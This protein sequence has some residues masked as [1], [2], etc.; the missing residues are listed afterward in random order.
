VA[1]KFPQLDLQVFSRSPHQFHGNSFNVLMA[2]K[3]AYESDARY[4]FMVEDDVMIHP[5]FFAWHRQQHVQPL[6]CSIAGPNPTK[7]PYTSLGVCFERDRLKMVLPHCRAEYFGNMRGYCK[8]H[9]PPTKYDCE[10][11]GLFCRLLRISQRPVVWATPP[12]ADHVGWYGYHRK[13]SPRPT[14][15]LEERYRHIKLV[16]RSQ[17]TLD[18]MSKDFKDVTALRFC[19]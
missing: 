12:L 17:T 15:T 8:F 2:Y 11:D 13:K 7:G 19:T 16:L 1:K 4:V 18:A 3:E 9:F 14:G 5:E 10:Q 6:F